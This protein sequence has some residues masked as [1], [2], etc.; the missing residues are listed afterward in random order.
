MWCGPG[1][2][3]DYPATWDYGPHAISACLGVV[4]Q[5]DSSSFDN[6]GDRGHGGGC[7]PFFAMRAGSRTCFVNVSNHAPAKIARVETEISGITVRY[8]AYASQAEA[9]L[10]REVRA[11]AQAVRAGGTDDWRFGARWAVD[12][13]RV[14]DHA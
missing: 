14:L 4:G 11:F 5:F 10:T 13:A 3:R 2:M 12:V 1:P 6:G 7:E 9:P 8:D